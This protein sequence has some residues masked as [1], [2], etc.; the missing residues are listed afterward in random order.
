MFVN[1]LLHVT[2][3]PPGLIDTGHFTQLAKYLTAN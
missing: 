1:V 3:V 2:S